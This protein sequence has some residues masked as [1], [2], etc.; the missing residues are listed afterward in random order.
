MSAS[1]GTATL[2]AAYAGKTYDLIYSISK[3][4]AGTAGTNGTNGTNGIDGAQ[5][6]SSRIVFQRAA[7]VPATPAASAGTPSGWYDTTTAVPAG[8]NPMW[9]TTGSTPLG[10]GNFTW[11][12]PVLVEAISANQTGESTGAFY[13]TSATL[14]FV[15]NPWQ[16]R[17]VYI[18]GDVP[19]PT[20]GG[21][22]YPQIEYR[23]AGGSWSASN[24]ST[25][26]YFTGGPIDASDLNHSILVSNSTFAARTYEV[27]GTIVRSNTNSGALTT[28]LSFLRI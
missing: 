5:G 24:G 2:R 13:T 17:N 23:E 21:I 3:A 14:S 7:T 26:Y 27:R 22:V 20:G 9:S 1:T 18:Q 6:I 15:L 4:I 12:A 8:S 11:G 10:G 16:S 28:A 19:S 25:W